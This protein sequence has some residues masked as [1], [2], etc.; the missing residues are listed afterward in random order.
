MYDVK[1][2]L[3]NITHNALYKESIIKNPAQLQQKEEYRKGC[4]AV[5]GTKHNLATDEGT[6]GFI[7]HST[8]KL[9]EVSGN[10]THWTPNPYT[11]LEYTNESKK[12]IRGHKR[13]AIK[14]VNSFVFDIDDEDLTLND[15]K[16]KIID[17]MI[18]SKLPEPTMIVETPR[19]FHLYYSIDSPFYANKKTGFK[20]IK[21]AEKINSNFKK[22]LSKH[23]PIDP[24]CVPFGFFRMPNQK[25]IKSYRDELIDTSDLIKWSYEYSKENPVE[26]K[27]AG[28]INY[29]AKKQDKET[30]EWVTALLQEKNIG[31][32]TN[33]GRNNVIF[34]L[35]LYYY[36]KGKEF[37]VAY[38]KLDEFNS[39]L[40]HP[41]SV[42]EFERV[43]EQ[44]YSGNYAGVSREYAVNIIE[45]YLSE[46]ITF[47]NTGIY[48][49]PPKPR[50]ER[51]RSHNHERVQDVVDYL[52][53]H[54]SESEPYI[55]GSITE[56]TEKLSISRSTFYDILKKGQFKQI[57]LKKEGKGRY[58]KAK[59][60]LK[61]LFLHRLLNMA[62]KAVKNNQNK[63]ASFRESIL[64]IINEFKDQNPAKEENKLYEAFIKQ[65]EAHNDFTGSAPPKTIQNSVFLI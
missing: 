41:L 42:K 3:E 50:E 46:S 38:D 59:L 16:E 26:R 10:T 7:V 45:T 62:K 28:V 4:V 6:K 65:I 27:K 31:S 48:Y 12:H 32:H 58:A 35:G 30:P 2:I 39:N 8:E 11:F 56:L 37:K 17:S 25:N 61:E 1:K 29:H 44:S 43:V 15:V 40:N 64:S 13:Q 5:V 51:E 47:N 34:T 20:A 54:T 14:Q 24:S 33:A 18:F 23:L 19:G 49:T 60:Y 57:V 55:E 9:A 22:A 53:T 63:K 52:K 36:S 21:M